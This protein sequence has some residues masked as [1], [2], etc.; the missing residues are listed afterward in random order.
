MTHNP[1][2]IL[3]SF[4]EFGGKKDEKAIHKLLKPY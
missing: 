3:I 1:D 2:F 4:T